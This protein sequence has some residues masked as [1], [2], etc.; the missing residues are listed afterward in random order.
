MNH[1]EPGIDFAFVKQSSI[2][3]TLVDDTGQA[4]QLYQQG[5][6]SEMA[7]RLRQGLE[8]LSNIM[9]AMQ[10]IKPGNKWP[11]ANL[12]Y[13]LGYLAVIHLFP[14][15][16]LNLA[17]SVKEFGNIGSHHTASGVNAASAQIDLE[18]FHDLLIYC[19]NAYEGAGLPYLDVKISQ[20]AAKHPDW[21]QRPVYQPS[22]LLSF[23][24]Y[25]HNRHRIRQRKK[26]RQEAAKQAVPER[27]HPLPAKPVQADQQQ[28]APQQNQQQ[29]AGPAKRSRFDHALN[30]ILFILAVLCLF[31]IL[32]LIHRHQE[33]MTNNNAQAPTTQTNGS[34][35]SGSDSNRTNQPAVRRKQA[36]SSSASQQ[37]AV[38]YPKQAASLSPQQGVAAALVYAKHNNNSYWQHLDSYLRRHDYQ[39]QRCKR[40][41]FGPAD[42][43]VKG[44][45][46]L[47]IM[48]KGVGIGMQYQ[49]GT[50]QVVFFDPGQNDPVAHPDKHNL[51]DI[52]A[53]CGQHQQTS[54]WKSLAKK[55][56]FQQ[57]DDSAE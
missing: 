18:Q 5:F 28:Q 31:V 24:Q 27:A 30:W 42:V 22:K 4:L 7:N 33:Q 56:Q 53:W 6:Y 41:V 17:F 8:H 57:T 48:R 38:S 51:S 10:G 49:N 36:P 50:P 32:L 37:P 3:N 23:D 16:I 40:Y 29:Q 25:L 43:Q 55:V 47:Y 19:T 13:R 1:S 44:D 12:S 9:L 26:P 39:I 21:Y 46:Y 15:R 52:L 54:D 14:Q 20:E 2:L 35:R 45:N 11:Q 34:T